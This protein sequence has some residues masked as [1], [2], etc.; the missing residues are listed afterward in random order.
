MDE[1]KLAPRTFEERTHA[2]I[3][4]ACA[5]ALANAALDLIEADSHSYGTRPCATCTAVSALAGRPFGCV[6]RAAMSRKDVL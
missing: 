3:I 4:T 5:R 2:D 1:D 6:K